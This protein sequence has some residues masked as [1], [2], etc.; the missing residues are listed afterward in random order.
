M[1]VPLRDLARKFFA[2]QQ[3]QKT[4][5]QLRRCGVRLR[6]EGLEERALM[7]GVPVDVPDPLTT[8][9]TNPAAVETPAPNPAGLDRLINALRTADSSSVQNAAVGS[10]SFN[11]S[12]TAVYSPSDVSFDAFP[13]TTIPDRVTNAYTLTISVGKEVVTAGA[14]GVTKTISVWEADNRIASAPGLMDSAGITI[15]ASNSGSTFVANATAVANVNVS[16]G[17][18]SFLPAESQVSLVSGTAYSPADRVNVAPSPAS[19]CLDPSTTGRLTDTSYTVAPTV[20]ESSIPTA[21]TTVYPPNSNGHGL[22]VSGVTQ[23]AGPRA[24][25]VAVGD[26]AFRV[27]PGQAAPPNGKYVVNYVRLPATEV[28]DGSLL[29]RYVAHREQAAFAALVQRHERFVFG[30]CRRVLGDSHAAED[31]FQ[32]TFLVLARKANMLDRD[33]P[34]TGWLYKVA[35]HVALRTRAISARQRTLEKK[36]KCSADVAT[37]EDDDLEREELRRVVNQELELLPE[38]YRAPLALCYLDGRTHEDAARELGLPRGSMA[39]RVAD[40]LAR[41]RERLVSRGVTL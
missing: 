11:G 38:K 35:Y 7:S 18:A 27:E 17:H 13:T 3:L 40:A 15:L 37:Q 16:A 9:V 36:A 34:I 32:A 24:I 41:L 39:K 6:L 12:S 5:R 29:H 22:T 30:I 19:V 26:G 25:Q 28:P 33:N 2:G 21:R 14:G 10:L 23:S 4:P 1:R 20:S 31:A 8:Q